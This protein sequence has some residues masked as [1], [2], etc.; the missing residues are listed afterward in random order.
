MVD[1][2]EPLGGIVVAET[3]H[4]NSSPFQTTPFVLLTKLNTA[5]LTA[6][7]FTVAALSASHLSIAL[8]FSVIEWVRFPLLLYNVYTCLELVTRLDT[9]STNTFIAYLGVTTPT[10][11]GAIAAT[12]SLKSNSSRLLF[13]SSLYKSSFTKNPN[14][15]IIPCKCENALTPSTANVA[16]LIGVTPANGT[17]PEILS[18]YNADNN[19]IP[20]PVTP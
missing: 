3:V 13:V 18:S 20:P 12:T 6:W 19:A 17:T 16:V 4:F 2:A 7:L 11:L 9:W 8:Y 15:G 14:L 10:G 1:V 5:A